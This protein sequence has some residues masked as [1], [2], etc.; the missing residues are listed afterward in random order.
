MSN[1]T[2]FEVVLMKINRNF[3]NISKFVK[4]FRDFINFDAFGVGGLRKMVK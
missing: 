4:N 2:F 1:L 3:N